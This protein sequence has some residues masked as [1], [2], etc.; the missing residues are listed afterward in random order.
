MMLKQLWDDTRGSSLVEFTVSV[1]LFLLLVFGLVQ[2]ALI[3]FTQTGLQHGV[4]AAARCASVN[5]SAKQL[6][7][8]ESCFGVAPST[9][10]ITTIQTY[11]ANNSW[12]VTPATAPSNFTVTP[13]G[14]CG[15][16]PGYKVRASYHYNIINYLF[17]LTL[18]AQS[19]FPINVS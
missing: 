18:T 4:E 8:S 19:C 17:N 5:Y 10:T 2:A 9:V 11:A 6:G 13:P 7:L 16:N 12:G 1:P 14:T 3:L 15:T